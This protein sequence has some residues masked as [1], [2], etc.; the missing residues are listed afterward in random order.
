[1]NNPLNSEQFE[2]LRQMDTCTVANAIETFN[3]RLRNEGFTDA[4]IRCLFPR[5]PAL[6]GY[7]VTVRIRCSSPPP[8]G[9]HYL[10]RTD[11]WDFIQSIPAPRVVVI[12]DVDDAPGTGSLLGEVHANILRALGCVGTVTN[13][14]VRDAPAVEALG[15]PLFAGGLTVSHAYAHIVSIGG[16]VKVAGLKIQ[17][18]DLLHGN[19]HGILSVPIDLARDIPAAAAQIIAKERRLITACRAGDFSPEKLRATLREMSESTLPRP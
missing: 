7:A 6:L 13:G 16:E 15:F 4:R 19:A 5:L 3:F 11:W 12:E 1:M 10:D 14:T 18:G 9:H 17:P 8:D 2:A